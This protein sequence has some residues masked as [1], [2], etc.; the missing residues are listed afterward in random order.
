MLQTDPE[1]GHEAGHPQKTWLSL[2]P[3]LLW[4]PHQA[5]VKAHDLAAE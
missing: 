5:G 4:T 3:P 2:A 1:V